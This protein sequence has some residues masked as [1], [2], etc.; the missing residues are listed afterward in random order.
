MADKEAN[1][2]GQA[3]RFVLDIANGRHVLS[4][5]IPPL[6][7]VLDAILCCLV[8]WK[9]PCKQLFFTVAKATY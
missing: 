1:I 7:L 5:A 9:I 8:I 6:L 2:F 3:V 4:K